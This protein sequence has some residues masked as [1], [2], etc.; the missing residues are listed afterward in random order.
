[1]KLATGTV[2]A[3]KVSVTD[4][5]EIVLNNVEV[6]LDALSELLPPS[7]PFHFSRGFVREVRI[8]IPWSFV[9]IHVRLDTVEI[10][11]STNDAGPPR[12][13]GSRAPPPPPPAPPD[14]DSST[15]EV[16]V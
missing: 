7:L 14:T 6:R 12:A 11:L 10:V 15:V 8:S 2:N 5:K 4:N 3:A 16:S 9:P 1:V 13:P